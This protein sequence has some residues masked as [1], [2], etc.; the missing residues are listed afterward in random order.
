M[1]P[2]ELPIMKLC[3]PSS[4]RGAHDQALS[5]ALDHSHWPRYNYVSGTRAIR[6]TTVIGQH[7]WNQGNQCPMLG[8]HIRILEAKTPFCLETC[9]YLWSSP[10][11]KT[12]HV[13]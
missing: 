4:F 12:V 9:G 7:E 10:P 6:V 5:S 11:S 13:Q 3:Q 2:V 1:A 8:F